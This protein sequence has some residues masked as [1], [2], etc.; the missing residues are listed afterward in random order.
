[1]IFPLPPE[2]EEVGLIEGIMPDSKE[3]YWLAQFLWANDII[4][5]YQWEIFGGTSRRG[6]LIVDFVAWL[7]MMTPIPVNGEYWH[8]EEMDSDL[9][10][11][12][13][14]IA[15]YFNIAVENIPILWGKD[16]QTKE[17]VFAWGRANVLR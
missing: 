9:R 1:V 12:L 13:V 11:N 10:Q 5:R 17:E 7:P 6:G 3:E 15:D 8:S 14:A 16:A 2:E 4:F